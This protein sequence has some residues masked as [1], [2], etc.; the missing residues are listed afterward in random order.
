[1][2]LDFTP[3]RDAITSHAKTLGKFRRVTGHEPMNAPGLELHLAVWLDSIAPLRSSGLAST[4]ALVTFFARVQSSATSQPA[5]D[6]DPAIAAAGSALIEA[7]SGDFTL[8]GLVRKIDL[9]GAYSPGLGGRAGY[10]EQD[11]RQFRVFTI[12]VPCAVNDV[13]PQTP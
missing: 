4:S 12:S 7:L 10:L 11:T 2:A 6:I 1:M 13:Y 9:L 5:D 3:I 8:G